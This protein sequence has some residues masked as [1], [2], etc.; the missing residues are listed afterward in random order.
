MSRLNKG[1]AIAKVF[2]HQNT[3][4]MGAAPLVVID[5]VSMRKVVANIVRLTLKGE[6]EDKVVLIEITDNGRGEDGANIEGSAITDNKDAI[7]FRAKDNKDGAVVPGTEDVED[8]E[9]G[10]VIF[11]NGGGIIAPGTE[12]GEDSVSP[13]TEGKEDSIVVFRNGGGVVLSGRED[14]EA[15]VVVF[16][17]ESQGSVTPRTEDGENNVVT[18]EAGND[19]DGVVAS[20]IKGDS[21]IVAPEIEEGK[22]EDTR[23][24]DEY[25]G[26]GAFAILVK[27]GFDVERMGK[28]QPTVP[29]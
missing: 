23:P 6:D 24:T 15:N 25:F 27:V 3:K 29:Y 5:R 18:P 7:I 22:D 14:G 11:R 4:I 8:S 10:I 20:R 26:A 13:R 17:A 2:I 21:D 16:R 1:I 9:D 19:E 28:R 12:D